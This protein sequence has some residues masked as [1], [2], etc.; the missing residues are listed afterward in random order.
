[1]PDTANDTPA[2]MGAI[3]QRVHPWMLECFG[4]EISFEADERNRRFFE[5]AVELVQA[6]GMSREHAHWMVDYVFSRA[7]GE[8]PAEV[9]GVVVTLAALC[10]A[11]GVNL[12]ATFEAE[13]ERIWTIVD[14]IRA[15]H[16]TKPRFDPESVPAPWGWLCSGKG[17]GWEEHESLVR[18]PVLAARRAAD[19]RWTVVPLVAGYPQGLPAAAA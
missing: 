9:G 12:E 14:R 13:V 17:D 1:M 18:D 2:P 19:P 6:N 10:T 3:Q 16:G 11:K 4:P 15:K 5:E 7:V 8:V